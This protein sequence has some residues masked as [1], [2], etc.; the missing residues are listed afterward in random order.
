[1][2]KLLLY[3]FSLKKN[4]TNEKLIINN[5]INIKT[6]FIILQYDEHLN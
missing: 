2:K 5:I 1:M 3:L 6:K 4:Y